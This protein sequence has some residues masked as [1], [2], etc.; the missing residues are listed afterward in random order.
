MNKLAG[1][2]VIVGFCLC[3]TNYLFVLVNSVI[4]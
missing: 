4:L 2:F 1:F 3:I